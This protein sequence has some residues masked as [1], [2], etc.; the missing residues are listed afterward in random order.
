MKRIWFTLAIACLALTNA[1]H[2]D[3]WGRAI[4]GTTVARMQEKQGTPA[5]DANK[6]PVQSLPSAVQDDGYPFADRCG[7]KGS[8][9]CANLW[10]GYANPCGCGIGRGMFTHSMR[11]LGCGRLLPQGCNT[12]CHSGGCDTGVFT[13][14]AGGVNHSGCGCGMSRGL[15][16]HGCGLQTLAACG[17]YHL[18]GLRRVCGLGCDGECS[19]CGD[20]HGCNSCNGKTIHDGG[21]EGKQDGK[22]INPPVPPALPTPMLDKAADAPTP[23]SEKSAFRPLYSTGAR[24]APAGF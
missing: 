3:V 20:S 6:S 9:C 22:T 14:F 18:Q 1:A 11:G 24:R 21:I 7:C 10:E 4:P 16:W 17:R 5:A 8:G 2:A 23:A 15:G 13:S 19:S 12:G